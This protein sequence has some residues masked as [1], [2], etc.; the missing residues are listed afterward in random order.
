MEIKKIGNFQFAINKKTVGCCFQMSCHEVENGVLT[1]DGSLEGSGNAVILKGS[2]PKG[3]GASWR[4][5]P[6][7]KASASPPL[8]CSSSTQQSH[9]IYD[10]L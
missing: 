3:G 10:S 5:F 2:G 1:Q 8:L 7:V 6:S 4:T 9:V